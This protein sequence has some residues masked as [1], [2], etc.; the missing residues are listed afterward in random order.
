MK[1]NSSS[2]VPTGDSARRNTFAGFFLQDIRGEKSETAFEPPCTRQ[3]VR[4][5]DAFSFVCVCI[6]VCE[7]VCVYR[8]RDPSKI[9]IDQNNGSFWRSD[10]RPWQAAAHSVTHR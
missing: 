7:C 3:A 2:V 4:A 5:Y 1:Q 9:F 10:R 6:C 8:R